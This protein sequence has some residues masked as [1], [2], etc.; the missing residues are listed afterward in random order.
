MRAI[1]FNIRF[2][3]PLD[4]P[5]AWPHRKQLVARLL[6][7]Y[8]PHAARLQEALRHQIDDLGRRLQTHRHLGRV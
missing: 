5:N 4:G 7:R 8:R 3:N 1:T 2:D 6:Q